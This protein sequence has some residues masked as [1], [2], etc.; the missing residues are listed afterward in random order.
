LN[1]PRFSLGAAAINFLL[2]LLRLKLLVGF[3]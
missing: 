1:M 2:V 3:I